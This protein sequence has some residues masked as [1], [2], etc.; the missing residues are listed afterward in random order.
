[1]GER[2]Q[3]RAPERVHLEMSSLGLPGKSMLFGAGLM[4][5]ETFKKHP[6]GDGTRIPDSDRTPEVLRCCDLGFLKRDI[7]PPNDG[8]FRFRGFSV[9][10]QTKS[11]I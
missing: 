4:Y 7:V 2:S 6:F 8:V 10:F 1:M 5:L 9:G 3:A 11:Y